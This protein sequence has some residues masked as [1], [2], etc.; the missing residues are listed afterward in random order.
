M[1]VRLAVLA[2]YSNISQEKKLNILG[3][4]DIIYTKN[5]PCFHHSMQLIMAL[6]SPYSEKGTPQDIRVRL[7]D[8]HGKIIVD[9]GAIL[10]VP[11]TIPLGEAFR[12]NQILTF[13]NIRFDKPGDYTFHILI[14]NQFK[15]EVPL[16]LIQQR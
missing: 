2:D 1:E 6:E 3:I 13:N 12:T 5:F 7:M 10:T 11:S 9:I 15:R 16:K 4:F 8:D 14:N